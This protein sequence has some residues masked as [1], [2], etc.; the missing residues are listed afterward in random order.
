MEI[1]LFSREQSTSQ[2]RRSK[3]V[4]QRFLHKMM[5]QILEESEMILK[6]TFKSKS[7]NIHTY[8]EELLQE[9]CRQTR[10]HISNQEVEKATSTSY[11]DLQE[12]IDDILNDNDDVDKERCEEMMHALSMI[13]QEPVE[14]QIEEEAMETQES[15]EDKPTIKQEMPDFQTLMELSLDNEEL[16]E[17]MLV[18]I[19]Y[20]YI[21]S[22][23][24]LH[25]IKCYKNILI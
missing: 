11:F 5:L 1:L 24:F 16:K 21:S 3:M 2:Q 14:D 22:Y 6:N 7:L 15:I 13:I 17:N 25:S 12:V 8:T 18:D 19:P 20:D 10:L 4:N 23:F 9:I